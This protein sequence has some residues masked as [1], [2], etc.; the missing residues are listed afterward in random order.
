[1][2]QIDSDIEFAD[3]REVQELL[4][5]LEQVLQEAPETSLNGKLFELRRLLQV[6]CMSWKQGDKSHAGTN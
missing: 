6:I 1:M 2:R 5:A 3:R 4:E